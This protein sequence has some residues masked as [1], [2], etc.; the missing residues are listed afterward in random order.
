MSG[1]ATGSTTPRSTASTAPPVPPGSLTRAPAAAAV[2]SFLAALDAWLEQLQARVN[3]LDADAQLAD[4]PTRYTGDVTLAMSLL[5]SIS[6]RHDELVSG[7]DSGRVDADALARIAVLL[8]GRLP[9]PLGAPSAF[10]MSEAGTLATALVDR[11]AAELAADPLAGSGVAGRVAAL[12]GAIGR[13]VAHARALGMTTT[14]L[15][16]S[17]AYLEAAVV[18]KD[19]TRIVATVGALEAEIG[20][21]ERDLIKETGLRAGTARLNAELL[22]ECAELGA[23]CVSVAALADRCRSR[24]AHAPK[25]AVPSVTVIGT[26]PEVVTETSVPTDW[27]AARSTLDQY[28]ARLH[29]VKAAVDQA[30]TAFAAPLSARDDLR[31][32]LGAYATRAARNGLAEDAGLTERYR[33][34]HDVLWN[35]PCDLEAAATLVEDYLRAVRRAVGADASDIP[36]R[37]MDVAQLP[38][39]QRQEDM[40]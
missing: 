35:A 25:L 8:W 15:E 23:R 7:W 17:A 1:V 26:P 34:A 14:D 5:H 12:R 2:Q 18:S 31:G 39:P 36:A 27:A 21:R 40:E 33:P 10:T 29:R 19:R 28:A 16:G 30:E 3:R 24:I 6:S 20:A 38:S 11:L 37:A 4:E 13:C 9:D 22:R 32:L